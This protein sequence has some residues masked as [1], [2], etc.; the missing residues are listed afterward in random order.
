MIL[1]TSDCKFKYMLEAEKEEDY[2]EII[3][4]RK[5]YGPSSNYGWAKKFERRISIN[6]FKALPT[7]LVPNQFNHYHINFRLREII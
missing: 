2:V 5:S 6:E 3:L 4:Y 1:T 7:L